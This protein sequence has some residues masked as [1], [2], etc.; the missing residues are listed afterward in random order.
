MDEIG[1][2]ILTPLGCEDECKEIHNIGFH[3][4]LR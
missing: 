4:G 1:Y 2:T 3:A